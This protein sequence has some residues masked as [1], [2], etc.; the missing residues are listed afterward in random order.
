MCVC[1]CAYRIY[2]VAMSETLGGQAA[3]NEWKAR[4]QVWVWLCR[5]D[6]ILRLV[7]ARRLRQKEWFL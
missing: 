7:I 6:Y 1:L 3:A 5:C 4:I 2:I